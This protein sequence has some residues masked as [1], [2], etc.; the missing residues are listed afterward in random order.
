MSQS[1]QKTDDPGDIMER[2][3]TAGD[4]SK[5]S[6][7]ERTHY[8][9]AVCQSIGLNP[10]TRPFEYITLNSKLTLYARKD[11]TDQLRRIHHVNVQIVS[12]ERIEDVYVVTARATLGDRQDES[13]G[14]VTITN[15]KGDG[16]ANA[17]MKAETKAKRRVTLSVCGLGFLDETET[18][19]IPSARLQ[20]ERAAEP[21]TSE[22]GSAT[23][24]SM[25]AQREQLYGEIKEMCAQLNG[26]GDSPR[27]TAITLKAYVNEKFI[28]PGGIDSLNLSDLNALRRDFSDK[29]D[30]LN[31]QETEAAF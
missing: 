14:A 21:H 29:L 17:L 11:A 23:G 3:I 31:D 26:A 2:V 13:I 28:V 25:N 20:T 6:A 27:W 19:T 24:L 8:Y 5:L 16:L 4:L 9:N 22:Q 12:R 10:L 30:A 7:M 1:L 15:L 18:E